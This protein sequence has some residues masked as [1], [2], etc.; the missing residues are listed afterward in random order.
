MA[1]GMTPEKPG[2]AWKEFPAHLTAGLRIVTI[3]PHAVNRAERPELGIQGALDRPIGAPALNEIARPRQKVALIVDDITRKTPAGLILPHVLSRL[4]EA[5]VAADDVR[6]VVALGTHRAM[7]EAEV[8]AKL[9]R[10]LAYKYEVVNRPC[11][12]SGFLYCGLSSNGIPAWVNQAVVEAD[13]RIGIGAIAPHPEAGYSGGAKIILPGVCNDVTVNAFHAR[14]AAANTNFFG[15]VGSPIRQA[16]ETF[17][18]DRVGLDFIVNAILTPD[19]ELYQCVAGHP[20]AAHRAG[21]RMA[22]QIYEVP[23]RRRYPVVIA[24][25]YPAELDFWQASKGLW[26]GERLVQDGGLLILVTESPEGIGPHPLYAEYIGTDP[27]ELQRALDRGQ[28]ADPNACAG[29]I[30]IGRMKRRVRFALVS[31]GIGQ[32]EAR[33]MGFGLFASVEEALAAESSPTEIAVLSHG[34]LTAPVICQGSQGD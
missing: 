34:G 3:G 27:D 22:G 14:G 28:V 16:L 11:W 29:G 8:V 17:V 10:D 26:S 2:A 31:P 20:I 33:A 1:Q 7:S 12:D 32:A 4:A 30:Q 23:V 18:I 6:I 13:V 21:V 9:G 24:D 15:T 25:S 19:G 5:G